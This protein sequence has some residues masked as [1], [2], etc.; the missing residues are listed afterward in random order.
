MFYAR[1]SVLFARTL[2]WIGIAQC[3]SPARFL[4]CVVYRTSARAIYLA[5][6]YT[7]NTG[8]L[9]PAAHSHYSRI[10]NCAVLVA[11]PISQLRR[12][13]NLCSCH[14]SARLIR[15][16]IPSRALYTRDSVIFAWTLPWIEIAQCQSLARFLSCAVY[17]TAARTIYLATSYAGNTLASVIRP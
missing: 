14:L 7:G 3:Q 1:D 13:S 6:S 16:A 4:S 17:Q 2:P 12:V 10:W 11:C 5:T 8:R 9:L 15:R